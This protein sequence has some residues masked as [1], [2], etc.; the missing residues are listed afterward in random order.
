MTGVRTGM[1]EREGKERKE[2]FLS[3]WGP[4]S[5]KFKAV[6]D[7]GGAPLVMGGDTVLSGEWG[8]CRAVAKALW[9][10]FYL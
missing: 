5:V 7:S 3:T 6:C 9:V 2:V 10:S 4:D 1:G 8:P